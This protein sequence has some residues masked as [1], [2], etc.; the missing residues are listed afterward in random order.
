MIDKIGMRAKLQGIA[1]STVVT[2]NWQA[3]E[4]ALISIGADN[5]KYK[6]HDLKLDI[7]NTAGVL[8]IKMYMQIWGVERELQDY[9]RTV[10]KGVNG[11]G[12]WIVTGTLAIHEVLRITCQSD[13]AADNGQG[14]SVDYLVEPM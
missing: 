7:N 10:S 4:Q 1:Y 11:S 5:V 6:L 3:A 14:I 13:N 9:R 2:A 8:T 12:I